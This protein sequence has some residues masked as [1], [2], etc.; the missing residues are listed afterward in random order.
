MSFGRMSV[1]EWAVH[2]GVGVAV[3]IIRPFAKNEVYTVN[4]LRERI[5][6]RRR[7]FNGRTYYGA[8]I[9]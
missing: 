1:A 2:L 3:W 9:R 8:A 7:A 6:E 4:K 5:V